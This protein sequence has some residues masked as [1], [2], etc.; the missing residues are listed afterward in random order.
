MC[1]PAGDPS[2]FAQSHTARADKVFCVSPSGEAGAWT[3]LYVC[4]LQA[5]QP[6]HTAHSTLPSP[7]LLQLPR[8]SESQPQLHK[9]LLGPE[10]QGP[11]PADVTPSSKDELSAPIPLGSSREILR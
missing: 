3:E 6:A 5:T 11:S 10:Q 9:S 1:G 4:A 7:R 2:P 8:T